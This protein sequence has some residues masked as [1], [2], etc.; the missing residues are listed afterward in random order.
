MLLGSKTCQCTCVG[1]KDPYSKLKYHIF[2]N[3]DTIL[4]K[5][6]SYHKFESLKFVDQIKITDL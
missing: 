5:F 4:N 3:Y 6:Q 2:H 1:F